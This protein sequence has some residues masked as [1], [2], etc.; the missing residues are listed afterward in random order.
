MAEVIVREFWDESAGA[1]YDTGK[2]HESLFIRPRNSYD[3]A[4]PS[5]AS[6]AALALLKIARITGRADLEKTAVQALRSMRESISRYP[7]GF[8]K[9][10]CALDFYLSPPLEVAILGPNSNENTTALT[11]VLYGTWLPNKVVVASDPADPTPIT[12]LAILEGKRMIDGCPT[13]YLCERFICH[14]PV[15][16]PDALRDLLGGS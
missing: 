9:W 8:C 14:E 2:R 10:L 7:L 15:T 13:V 11:R 5:G 1:F 12:G 16:S 6:A 4:V 3:N